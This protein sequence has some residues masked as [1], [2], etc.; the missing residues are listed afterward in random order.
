M[1]MDLSA[2]EKKLV[3]GFKRLSRR[4]QFFVIT[5][6]VAGVEMEENARRIAIG[7]APA[8][9]VYQDRR[10]AQKGAALAME[11]AV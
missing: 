1:N 7:L 4:S 2:D 6:V 9:P 5:Q 11:A 3:D 10:P 8:D